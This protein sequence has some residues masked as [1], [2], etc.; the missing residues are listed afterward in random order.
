MRKH[1]VVIIGGSLAGAACARELTRLGVDAIA[2]ERDRFPRDKV[3]GGFLSA[4]AVDCLGH[5][6]VL[7]KVKSA[8]ATTVTRARIRAG[9]TDVEVG[10]DR[11][12]L[13]ISRSSLDRILAGTPEVEQGIAVQDVERRDDSFV[14]NNQIRC[15]VVIDA[16][17]KLSRFTRRRTVE[18]F[19]VQYVE[20]GGRGPVL[21][22]WFRED[23]YG[24]GVSIE[25]GRSNFCFLIKKGALP[26]YLRGREG[27]MVTGPLAYDRVPG[28]FIAIGDAAGMI[29]PFCGEGMRHAL[30]TG[31]L[32]AQVV[33]MGLSRRAGYEEIKRE[34]D[35]KWRS[36]W[37]G[38]RMVGAA[39]RRSQSWFGPALKLA[40][41][42]MVKAVMQM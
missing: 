16:A 31:I 22:F 21:D 27:C 8:G 18:E 11:P 6:N 19:G 33:S 41:S 13:G 1:D 10:F 2:L 5:L 38:R 36:R 24:G 25:G 28:E 29:D 30:E 12:G 14:V 26:E 40:P 15:S 34:Y 17:G 4:G 3:C 9:S 35:S 20:A 32:S 7:D 42:W 23:G 39:L 37:N